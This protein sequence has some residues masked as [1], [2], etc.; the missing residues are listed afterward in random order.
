M[1]AYQFLL[2]Y[3]RSREQQR[4]EVLPAYQQRIKQDPS[5]SL[6]KLESGDPTPQK[7]YVPRLAQWWLAG[8][9][10]ED[11]ISTTA[12]A[13]AKYHTLKNKK[14][15]KPEHADIGRFKTADQF[16]DAVAQYQHVGQEFCDKVRDTSNLKD[17]GKYKQIYNDDQLIVIELL[18]I[19][20]AK[21]WGKNTKWC[22]TSTNNNMF[23]HYFR[24]GPLYVIV[25]CAAN[26]RYQFWWNKSD[27]Y[28]IQFKNVDD[29]DANPQQLT[30]YQKLCSI[31]RP[32]HKHIMWNPD[33]TEQKQLAELQKNSH[34]IYFIKN[35]SERV[36]MAAVN[37]DSWAIQWIENPSKAVQLSAV[38]QNG[39]TIYSI[40][41]PSKAVQLAAVKENGFVIKYIKNPSLAVQQAAVEQTGYAIQYI[42]NPREAVQMAAVQQDGT[43]I[44]YIKNPTPRVQALAKELGSTK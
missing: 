15:I 33:A 5:F 30:I 44:H 23:K 38:E 13:L 10:I 42:N 18:D 21:W 19:T 41:N 29:K 7:I 6:E 27:V 9:P 37:Q 20:A 3:D 28:D 34:A 16:I 11:L 8:K 1:R 31:M 32:I 26:A 4:I 43:A 22:T 24:R 36:Q 2:E 40:K 12:D 35:P 14:L 17:R 39:N 25:D